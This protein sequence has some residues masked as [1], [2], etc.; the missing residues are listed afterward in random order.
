MQYILYKDG[1]EMSNVQIITGNLDLSFNA[2]IEN[3]DMFKFAEK[4]SFN[5]LEKYYLE[6]TDDRGKVNFISHFLKIATSFEL[7]HMVECAMNTCYKPMSLEVIRNLYETKVGMSNK[8]IEYL[9]SN[10]IA[11]PRKG[12]ESTY[13]Y[14]TVYN[15]YNYFDIYNEDGS[16]KKERIL[17]KYI[18]NKIDKYNGMY[19]K[20]IIT[21]LLNPKLEYGITDKYVEFKGD[22]YII[23]LKAGDIKRKDIYQIYDYV[24]MNKRKDIPIL[25]GFDIDKNTLNLANELNINVYT[26]KVLPLVPLWIKFETKGKKFE[27]IDKYIGDDSFEFITGEYD[28]LFSIYDELGLAWVEDLAIGNNALNCEIIEVICKHIYENFALNPIMEYVNFKT[29]F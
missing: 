14:P 27:L 22:K 9:N 7:F 23:E 16:L 15:I 4:E 1:A 18:N 3:L 21:K 8:M 12:N 10:I 11:S 28:E 17:Q 5:C 2:V 29:N 25:I 24:Y 13:K 26:Y 19:N 20:P 6:L